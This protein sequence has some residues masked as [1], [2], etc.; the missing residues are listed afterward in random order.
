MGND[1]SI[2][3]KLWQ[4]KWELFGASFS[5][6]ILVLAGNYF[7]NEMGTSIFRK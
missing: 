5:I 2:E 3:N 6:D 4:G 1:I 7:K